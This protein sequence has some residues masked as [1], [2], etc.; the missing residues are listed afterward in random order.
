MIVNC[1]LVWLL[2]KYSS[3]PR[4]PMRDEKQ[5]GLSLVK[6]FKEIE[7]NDYNNSLEKDGKLSQSKKQIA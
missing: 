2:G 1:I 6:V 3:F 7:S 4:D 5:A